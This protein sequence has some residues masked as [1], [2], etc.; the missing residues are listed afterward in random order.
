MIAPIDP[1]SV[2]ETQIVQNSRKRGLS[3]LYRQVYVVGHE[4][5]PVDTMPKSF[6]PLLNQKTEAS[7]ILIIEENILTAITPKDDVV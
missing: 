4:T 2:T 5:E 6:N 1:P 7:P 3:H